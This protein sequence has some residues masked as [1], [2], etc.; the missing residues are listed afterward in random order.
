MEDR[1]VSSLIGLS[2]CDALGTAVEFMP[3]GSFEEVK[4]LRGGGKF[5]LLPGQVNKLLIII[6][7]IIH[8]FGIFLVDR[9]H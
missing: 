7:I 8:S 9:R 5:D 1:F 2:V 6:K 4:D 3:R